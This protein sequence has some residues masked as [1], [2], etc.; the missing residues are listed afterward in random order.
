MA[1]PLTYV[2]DESAQRVARAWFAWVVAAILYVTISYPYQAIV[3]RVAGPYPQVAYALLCL[4][5]ATLMFWYWRPPSAIEYRRPALIALLVLTAAMLVTLVVRRNPTVIRDLLLLSLIVA[6]WF[7]ARG[8]AMLQLMRTLVYLSVLVFVPAMIAVSLFN[9]GLLDWPS[10]SVERFGLSADNPLAIRAAGGDARYYLP[11]SLGIVPHDIATDQGFGLRF[12]RQPLVF[13]EPTGLWLYSVGLFWYTIADVRMP[14][15]IACLVILGIALLVSFSVAGILATLAAIMFCMAFAAGGRPLVFALAGAALLL[16][17][18][19]PI[20]TLLTLV[21]FDKAEQFEFYSENLTVLS[22]LSPFGNSPGDTEE[23]QS[24]GL[25]V[26]LDRYGIV[27][28]GVIV[29]IIALMAIVSFRILRDRATLGWRRFPL[30]IGCFVTLA[31]LFK[32][33][34]IVPAAPAICL[35]AALSLRHVRVAPLSRSLLR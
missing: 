15:R 12:V 17:A 4:F 24:Y 3:L 7:R 13:I 19:V 20:P 14:G 29:A 34:G 9:A 1:V 16:L 27:G 10:W 8:A 23:V 6:V 22:R 21:A 30:F 26:V 35:A 2:P 28:A 5:G 31:M 11:L 32:Y 25:L 33:P 18:L